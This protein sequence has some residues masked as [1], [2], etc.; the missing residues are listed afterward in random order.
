MKPLAIFIAGLVVVFGAFAVI[1]N[2][3]R[4]TERVFVVV[5]SSFP[6]TEVWNQVP[7]VLDDI[8]DRQYAEF[9]LATEKD[10]VHSWQEDLRL[11]TTTPFAPCDFSEIETYGEVGEADELILITS[12]SSCPTDA[13]T[14]WTVTVLTP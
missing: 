12:S 2:I 4:D 6:M 3:V 1:L 13:F 10:L 5:D 7:G 8:D 9:A 14:D 11:G